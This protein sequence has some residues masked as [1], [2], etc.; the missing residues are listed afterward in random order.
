MSLPQTEFRLSMRAEELTQIGEIVNSHGIKGELKILPFTEDENLF[1]RLGYLILLRNNEPQILDVISS[2]PF[3]NFWLVRLEGI[4]DMTAAESLKGQ[5]VFIE[6]EK[7]RPLDEDEF[8]IHDLMDVEVY[9]TDDEYLG[10]ITKFFE[11]GNQG[12]FEV[13]LN[14]EVFLF[15]ASQEILKEID[16]SK[17]VVIKLVPGLRE[18]NKK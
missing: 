4:A 7:L 6:D 5:A 17:R 1:T 13:T 9:S 10:V 18:L 12:V 16:P 8:F 14:G 11:T 15:P 2:R 3:K